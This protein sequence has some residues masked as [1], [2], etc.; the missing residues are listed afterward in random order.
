MPNRS[1][2]VVGI[3][4]VLGAVIAVLALADGSDPVPFDATSSAPDGYRAIALMLEDQGLAVRSVAPGWVGGGGIAEGDAQAPGIGDAVVVPVAQ[5]ATDDELDG[6]RSLAETG[7]TVVLAAEESF[8]PI[9]SRILVRSSANPVARGRCDIG[10][11][12]SLEALDDIAFE[13]LADPRGEQRVCFA[14]GFGALVSSEPLG[15]GTIVHL[16]SPYLWAN[17]RLQPDKED[18]GQPLDNGP[19]AVA[20]LAGTPG[21][22][23]TFVE[24]I[25]PEG[26]SPDGSRNPIELMPFPVKIALVQAAFA[27]G[28]YAW[29]KGRRVGAPVSEE[30]P[31]EVAGSELVEAVGGLLRRHGSVGRASAVLRERVC[32]ELASGLGVP[33]EAGPDA[34]TASV[35]ARTGRGRD[36]VHAILFGA[37]PPDVASLLE[38]SHALDSLHSEVLSVVSRR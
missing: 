11:L 37:Q 2:A 20:L 26:T 18:G 9:D 17:A 28:L 24:A 16:S 34:L 27:F 6:Y 14:D 35:A 31:V 12:E 13:V 22:T 38:L 32:R 33:R 8:F 7:A 29:W 3:V 4:L 23:V 15:Q 21:A 36:E 19:M 1:A 5:W 30:M 25:A 10:S